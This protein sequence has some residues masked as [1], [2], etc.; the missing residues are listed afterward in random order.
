MTPT[1]TEGAAFSLMPDVVR[2]NRAVRSPFVLAPESCSGENAA[3]Q[4]TAFLGALGGRVVLE[5]VPRVQ[6]KLVEA[7]RATAALLLPVCSH[8]S[9]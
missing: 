8:F 2:N 5:T 9:R 7:G 1:G 3:Q 4:H 6:G